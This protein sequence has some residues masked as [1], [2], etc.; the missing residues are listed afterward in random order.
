MFGLGFIDD[1]KHLGARKK[2]F[3]QVTRV[4]AIGS[5]FWR[6]SR[7]IKMCFL[8]HRH[9]HYRTCNTV[10]SNPWGGGSQLKLIEAWGRTRVLPKIELV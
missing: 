5:D 10:H 1:L 4:G 7:R 3:G 6:I 8:G 2:L 9:L